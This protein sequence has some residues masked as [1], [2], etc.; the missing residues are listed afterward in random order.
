MPVSIYVTVVHPCTI[1]AAS[2]LIYS[3]GST[4][5]S[6]NLFD[7]SSIVQT[8]LKNWM[9]KFENLSRYKLS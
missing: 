1:H 5:F 2:R 6:L 8:V 7:D 4:I 9:I 3:D